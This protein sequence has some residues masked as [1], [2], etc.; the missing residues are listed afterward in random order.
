[1]IALCLALTLATAP[2]RPAGGKPGAR[3][4]HASAGRDSS[5]HRKMRA[6]VADTALVHLGPADGGA[7]AFVA[8]PPAVKS[9]P[10]VVV[11]HE[12]WGLN[13]EIRATARRL[14]Q[15]G[16][17][18]IVPDLYHGKV[19]SDPENAHVLMRGIDEGEALATL[20]AAEQWLAADSRTQKRR[21][22]ILGFCMGGGLALQE[23]IDDPTLAAAVIFYGSPESRPER[24]AKLA[25]PLLGHYGAD[26]QGI[27]V[28]R[29]EAF[30]RT[31]HGA[32]KSA[33]IDVYAGAGHAFMNEEQASY[34]P[35]A[36]R[37]AW[38]RTLDFLQ[39]HLKPQP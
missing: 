6:A 2:S 31:L 21:R 36:A 7:D 1:M 18:A 30:D 39:K 29:V 22:G 16:Y 23:A 19:A 32:G 27:D 13:A 38:A 28:S 33:E 26:D 12:W 10:G 37:L 8:F 9:A 15:Q 4:F 25:V 24:I 17:V 20:A 14:A 34:R 35:E 3:P 5:E 11:V